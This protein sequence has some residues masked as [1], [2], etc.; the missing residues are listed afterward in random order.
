MWEG[1]NPCNQ[2]V[3]VVSGM[4]LLGGATGCCRDVTYA[5]G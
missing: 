4:V 3:V 2:L 1:M 5:P